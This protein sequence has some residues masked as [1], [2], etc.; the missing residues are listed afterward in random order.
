MYALDNSVSNIKCKF[1]SGL[2]M[3]IAAAWPQA[4]EFSTQNPHFYLPSM[5][6]QHG[7][8]NHMVFYILMWYAPCKF[9]SLEIEYGDWKPIEVYE[10]VNL[11]YNFL[12]FGK[13]EGREVSP[14]WLSGSILSSES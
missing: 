7:I 3:K 10:G 11:A 5:Q 8:S 2:L 12:I 9:A 6:E 13:G 14:S 1:C 4:A